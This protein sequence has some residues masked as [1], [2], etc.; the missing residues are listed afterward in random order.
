M[1]YNDQLFSG[2]ATYYS[3]YRIP[4][5]KELL[6]KI[7]REWQAQGDARL[8]DLG[9][10]TG[11]L[12]IPL[13]K[14][15]SEVVGIDISKEMVEEASR[16]CSEQDVKNVRFLVMESEQMDQGLGRF[17]FITCGNAF[18]WMD[19][20]VVLK[21]AYAVLNPAGEM[22]IFA[23][24]SI[25]TGKQ[26]WQKATLKIIKKWLGEKRKAGSRSYSASNKSFEALIHE[27]EF[28]LVE[29]GKV[30]FLHTWRVESLIGYLYST[31]YC[32]QDLLGGNKDAFEADLKEVLLKSSPEGL[33]YEE[34]EIDYFLL[35]KR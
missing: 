10:G 13:H 1:G 9:C 26:E 12:A 2:T 28:R 27:S 5:P 23:G 11:Q 30:S 32:K 34:V 17:D 29:K 18:H 22:A 24:G 3:R 14:T 19:Q 21:K 31:S 7:R 4:Y 8:L 16:I 20:K 25:W 33:F 35:K 15:F 6:D